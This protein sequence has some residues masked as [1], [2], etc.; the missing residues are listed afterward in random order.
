MTLNKI[1]SVTSINRDLYLS[2]MMA[3][4]VV[5]NGHSKDT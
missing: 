1:F 5:K 2:G 3:R 4:I